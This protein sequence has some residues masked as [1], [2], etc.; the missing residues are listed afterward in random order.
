MTSFNIGIYPVNQKRVGQSKNGL[1]K[2]IKLASLKCQ[3]E[4][5]NDIIF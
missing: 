2:T 1:D 4:Q 5:K 3:H